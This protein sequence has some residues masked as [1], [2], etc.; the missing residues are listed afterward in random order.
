MLGFTETIP[1]GD[2]QTWSPTHM[3]TQRT[4]HVLC[5]FCFSSLF[6]YNKSTRYYIILYILDVTISEQFPAIQEEAQ[7]ATSQKI[8]LSRHK[9]VIF[10]R[11]NLRTTPDIYVR[12]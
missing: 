10:F 12:K 2:S 5:I 7:Q 3:K 8:H 6:E 9:A 11:L 1:D 4:C